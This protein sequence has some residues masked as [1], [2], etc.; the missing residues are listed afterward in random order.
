ME[1]EQELQ[2]VL[3]IN[4]AHDFWGRAEGPMTASQAQTRR[5]RLWDEADSTGTV[6][7]IQM[8]L[9]RETP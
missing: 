8:I 4:G 9:W 1:Q 2:Y 6:R 5:N 7:N 3:V